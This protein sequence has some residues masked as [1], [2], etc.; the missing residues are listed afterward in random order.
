[1]ICTLSFF[2][3]LPTTLMWNPSLNFRVGPSR[4][5]W[6]FSTLDGGDHGLARLL[7][8]KTEIVQGCLVGAHGRHARVRGKFPERHAVLEELVDLLERPA[9]D[10]G[11]Q[12]VQ[13]DCNRVRRPRCS[14][15]T[16]EARGVLTE[17]HGVGAGPD[18]AVLAAPVEGRGVEE[19]GRA[20]RDEPCGGRLAGHTPTHNVM[21]MSKVGTHRRRSS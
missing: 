18:V 16:G 2:L 19:E 9:L 14:T 6:L 21:Y 11:Q 17:S 8:V 4:L 12:E 15:G 3:A 20:V 5:H 13:E 10:L 1:M 7:V